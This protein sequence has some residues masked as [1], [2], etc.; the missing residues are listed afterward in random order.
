MDH[1]KTPLFTALVEHAAGEPLPF[2]IP[3]HKKGRGMDREFRTFLGDNT[4]SIDLINIVP[5]DDLHQPTGVIQ[6]AE[7][8]AADAFDAD[9]TLF[10]V[11][12]TTG[13]IMTMIMSLCSPGD[14][15]ILPRNAHKSILSAV[16]MSGSTPVFISP[17]KDARLG[18][19]HGVT[20]KSVKQALDMNRN[21][22][23]VLSSIRLIMVHVSICVKWLNLY[24]AMTFQCSWTKP[25][26][27]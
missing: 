9:Y 3:G 7:Q 18:I 25:T 13:A 15:I 27:R 14:T 11:Q 22:K 2:H 4:L 8:L 26:A 16:I 24:T 20:L 10:S 1:K 6:E 19:D 21:A 12:G 5:L 17:A 23:A